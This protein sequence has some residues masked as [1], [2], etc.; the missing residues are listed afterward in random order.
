M[1]SGP[2]LPSCCRLDRDA[3]LDES[4]TPVNEV[5]TDVGSVGADIDRPLEEFVLLRGQATVRGGEDVEG[6]FERLD[7]GTDVGGEMTHEGGRG[8]GGGLRAARP[9][10]G[11]GGGEAARRRTW[12]G[13]RASP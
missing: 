12:R 11:G 4:S 9:G 13:R 1:A 10:A 2:E 8:G 6:G 3:L 5:G 7:L